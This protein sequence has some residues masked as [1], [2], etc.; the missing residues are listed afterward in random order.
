[1][2]NDRPHDGDAR[3]A[4]EQQRYARWLDLGM[5]TGLALLALTFAV[6]VFGWL[7]A[8]VPFESLPRLW[9]LPVEDYLREAGL[10][11]GWTWLWNIGHGDRLALTGIALLAGISLPCLALLVPAYW[12]RGDRAH[13][14]IALALV[15]LL[16]LA[17]SGTINAH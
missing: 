15:G 14:L 8:R 3:V 4:P 7:P 16:A 5:R 13:A 9:T 10:A 17:A 6:Y 12:K 1:M 11:P 2:V